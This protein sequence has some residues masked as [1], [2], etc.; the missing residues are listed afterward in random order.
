MKRLMPVFAV[1]LLVAAPATAG[2]KVTL[3]H[4]PPGS[5]GNVQ[6]IQ[7]SEDAVPAHLSHGDTLGECTP[8]CLDNSSLCDDGNPCTSDACL[9]GGQCQHTPVNCDD[10]NPCTTDLCDEATGCL[11]LPAN[12]AACDDGSV[13]TEHDTCNNGQC[14]GVAIAG[15]C[16]TNAQC[17]DGD[18]CTTD[19]CVSG[20]CQYAPLVCSVGD[21]C[22]AGFCDPATGQCAATPVSCD[23]SNVCTDDSCDPAIGCVHVPTANPP[24]AHETFCND[25]VDNDCDGFTDGAD[26][27]CTPACGP[28]F[29]ECGGACVNN[30]STSS[31]GASCTPCTPPANATS[32]CDGTTCGFACNPGFLSCGGVCVPNDTANCGAC[33]HVCPGPANGNGSPTCNSGSCGVSCNPGLTHCLDRCVD[34]RTDL[35]NCGQ[36]GQ[37]CPPVPGGTATCNEGACGVTCSS[38]SDNCDGNLANGCETSL[39]TDPNNCGSCGHVCLSPAG[40]VGLGNPMCIEGTCA[41]TCVPGLVVCGASG[42]GGGACVEPFDD[43]AN[44]GTCG[45][46]CPNSYPNCMG[47]ACVP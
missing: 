26:S 35:N 27:D 47:G 10:G 12:G 3:C 28:G 44:C 18:A 21:K 41:G 16:V 38:G 32:S 34:L 40:L 6:T 11:S 46:V 7:V 31:C 39:L 14:T 25:G 9:P 24:Q 20:R 17:D 1:L 8:S 22:L 45:H 42:D 15:C 43:P 13:C 5:P 2:K 4:R 29:H 33:G 30:N 23:D 37:S 19:T 36:C